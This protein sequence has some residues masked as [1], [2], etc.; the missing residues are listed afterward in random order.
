MC[1]I[2]FDGGLGPTKLNHVLSLFAFPQHFQRK[3]PKSRTDPEDRRRKQRKETPQTSK[4]KK[5][6]TSA[7][8]KLKSKLMGHIQ[9]DLS[10]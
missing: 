1:S 4:N 8:K 9:S 10:E 3:P 5:V 2:D 7:K 6:L